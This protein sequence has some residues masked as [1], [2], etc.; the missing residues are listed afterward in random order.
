MLTDRVKK[1][2]SEGLSL[3]DIADKESIPLEQVI[4]ANKELMTPPVIIPEVIE[5]DTDSLKDQVEGAALIAIR[6]IKTELGSNV[7]ATEIAKLTDSVTKLHTTFFK[8]DAGATFNIQMTELTQF[9][10][11]LKE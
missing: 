9:R 5:P 7:D 11:L 6:K 3:M 4:L 1:L 2:K 10:T 8:Q